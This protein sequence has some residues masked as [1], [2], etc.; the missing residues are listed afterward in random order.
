P[1]RRGESLSPH[2]TFLP[3]H[4]I[5]SH[6]AAQS[7]GYAWGCQGKT[8]ILL[9]DP[10]HGEA[11]R[12]R[13]RNLGRLLHLGSSGQRGFQYGIHSSIWV[14]RVVSNKARALPY[15][16]AAFLNMPWVV[17]SAAG[18]PVPASSSRRTKATRAGSVVAAPSRSK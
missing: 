13:A 17:M 15:Q 8:P 10:G 12:G 7:K 18:A 4:G 6:L 2:G 5:S 3:L 11:T 16:M 14:V 1:P 9:V